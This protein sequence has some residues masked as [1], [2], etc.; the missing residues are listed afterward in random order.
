MLKKFITPA[1]LVASALVANTAMA[2]T[3]IT[4]VTNSY[5][6]SNSCKVTLVS[7]YAPPTSGLDQSVYQVTCGAKSYSVMQETTGYVNCKVFPITP[8]ISISGS[9]TN[10]SIYKP[11]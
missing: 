9:C 6:A 1:L 8:G 5:T 3:L 10:Y 11:A 2:D 7:H 4:T